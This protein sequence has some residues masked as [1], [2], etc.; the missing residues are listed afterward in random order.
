MALKWHLPSPCSLWTTIGKNNYRL[1][2]IICRQHLLVKSPADAQLYHR[3]HLTFV[4]SNRTSTSLPTRDSVVP[5]RGRF[6]AINR[7]WWRFFKKWK[8][9][10]L[11]SRTRAFSEL[12]FSSGTMG[13]ECT[14][15]S[16]TCRPLWPV[17]IILATV[18]CMFTCSDSSAAVIGKMYPRGNHWAVGKTIPQFPLGFAEFAR[19][20]KSD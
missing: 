17:F 19:W 8:A 6:P 2:I 12:T 3:A 9:E 7:P 1:Q 13:G 14:C 10:H 20:F 18:S 11:H 5:L 4:I 15:Y 16:R